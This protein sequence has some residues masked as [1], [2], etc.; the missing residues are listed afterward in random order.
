[1]RKIYRTKCKKYIEC[2]KP[3]KSYICYK[4]LLFSSIFDK[5]GTEDKEI[6]IEK[7]SI[8]TYNHV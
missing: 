7:E 2:K 5:C 3:T 8:E 6:F 1:M 4:T